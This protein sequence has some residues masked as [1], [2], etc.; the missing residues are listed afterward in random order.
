MIARLEPFQL[1]ER[2]KQRSPQSDNSHNIEKH[3][4]RA[5]R[6]AEMILNLSGAAVCCCALS[7]SLAGEWGQSSNTRIECGS[8]VRPYIRLLMTA[9]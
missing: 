5:L 8:K 6:E 4:E 1:H 3:T 2:K 7:A 9:V